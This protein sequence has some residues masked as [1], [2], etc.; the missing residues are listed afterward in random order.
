MRWVALAVI[1]CLVFTN[2]LG[3]E[4]QAKKVVIDFAAEAR[5]ASVAVEGSTAPVL[6]AALPKQLQDK[7][8]ENYAQNLIW[9]RDFV[10]R[11]WEWHLFSTKLLFW[12]VICIVLFGLGITYVQFR[13]DYGVRKRRRPR[14]NDTSQEQASAEGSFSHIKIGAGGLELTS[15]VIGL[16]VLI[17]S[18]AFFY[19][20]VKNVYPMQEIE[21]QRKAEDSSKNIA[22]TPAPAP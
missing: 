16:F 8:V 12:I 4:P 18:L 13:K 19:F 5:Q 2:A 17:L 14:S 20:Y 7:D 15:Q 10:T 9:Q 22:K 3:V 21:L 1:S 11:T 6:S